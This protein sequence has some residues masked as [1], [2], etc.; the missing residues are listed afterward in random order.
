MRMAVKTRRLKGAAFGAEI[1]GAKLLDAGIFPAVEKALIDHGLL[2]FREAGLTAMAQLRFMKQFGPIARVTHR[3][4]GFKGPPEISE[5][6]SR[7]GDRGPMRFHSDLAQRKRPCTVSS[8]YCVEAPRIGGATIF[9]DMRAA[10]NSLPGWAVKKLS[11]RAA[12]NCCAGYFCSNQIEHSSIHPVFRT[13]PATGGKAIFVSRTSTIK[14]MG[15]SAR[16]SSKMLQFLFDYQERRDFI[17]TH[18]WSPGDFLLFD[19]RSLIHGR[20]DFK[21][22]E[23]RTVRL[24]MAGRER[25]A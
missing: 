25:P 22:A 8:L 16:E 20:S 3:P 21:P 2:L 12:L 10:Y 5:L 19:N 1:S 24:V 9:A 4:A 7:N 23:R 17:Y 15:L 11:G 13:H 14:I 18:R 6:S